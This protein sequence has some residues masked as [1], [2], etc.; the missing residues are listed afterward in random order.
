MHNRKKMTIFPSIFHFIA[1]GIRVDEG[2]VIVSN[3]LIQHFIKEENKSLMCHPFGDQAMIMWINAIENVTYFGDPRVHHEVTADKPI[4]EQYPEICSKFLALHG[5]Y[6]AQIEQYWRRI[7]VVR[8]RKYR[9]PRITYPCGNMNKT[10]EKNNF[11]GMYYAD[12]IPCRDSPVWNIG[13][14]YVGRSGK[15]EFN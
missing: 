5:S 14:M 11:Q 8:K 3:D 13:N 9:V 10:F 7:L 15:T 1:G 2:F 6:P 12:P 4:L